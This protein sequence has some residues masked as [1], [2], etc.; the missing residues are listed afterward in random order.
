MRPR[1]DAALG[2][3]LSLAATA[4][5]TGTIGD[6]AAPTAPPPDGADSGAPAGDA[7]TSFKCVPTLKPPLDQLRLLTATQYTNTLSD[8]ISWILADPKGGASAI[9]R[10]GTAMGSL[11]S[12]LPVVP[13]ADPLMAVLFPDGGYVR[14]DQDQQYLRVKAYYDIGVA[15]GADLTSAA[16]LAQV[17]GS[18]ATDGNA[19]NDAACL[20]AFIKKIGPRALR[21]PLDAA[22]VTFFTSVY[23]ADPK[24]D[25]AAYADVL[26][27]MLNAPDFVY[28]VEHGDKTVA[29]VAGVYTLSAHELASRLSYQ[30]WDTMPDDALWSAAE[31]A[32][33]LTDAAYAKHVDRMFS[34]PRAQKALERFFIDYLQVNASGGARGKGGLNYHNLAAY[35]SDPVFHAFAA[36]DLPSPTLSQSMVDDAVAMLDYFVFTK[37]GT[38]GDLLES[39]L[40]F[41][42]TP[43]L[44]M[45]YG[46]APWDGTAAPPKLPAGQRPGLFTRA[47]VVASGVNTSPI[48]KGVYLRRYVL[49]DDVGKPPAA[50]ANATV[51]LSTN[52]TTRQVVTDLTKNPPCS[53]CHLPLINPLGFTTES[54]DGLGRFRTMQTLFNPDGTVAGSLPVDTTAVPRVKVDDDKTSVQGAADLMHVIATSGKLEACL[55]RNYFRHTFAR[56]ENIELDGCTLESMRQKLDRAK[57]PGLLVDL[58]KQVV[59][60]QAFKQRRF[61]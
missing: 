48:L 19:S 42:K 60:T 39:D 49:C 51:V 54:F 61:E 20:D 5:C 6:G 38:I 22:D 58:L 8:L 12:N 36:G 33:L 57:G 11:Q 30:V 26:A 45:I 56:F 44:A 17:V 46:V 2:F 1:L 55:A 53:G 7:P 18:C 13:Q 29:G 10:V 34:D 52:E 24:A 43:D 41:A 28:F 37:P 15:V 21:R 9:V 32:T 27:A 40:S 47:A 14:A 3:A 25:P 59:F 50:A 23:G 35:N 4:A 31:D 16:R